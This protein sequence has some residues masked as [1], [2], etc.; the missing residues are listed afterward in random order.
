MLHVMHNGIELVVAISP[1]CVFIVTK[2]QVS[3]AFSSAS[4]SCR[5][6]WPSCLRSH[7]TVDFLELVQEQTQPLPLN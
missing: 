4:R 3:D 7:L 1:A 2:K 6:V 5:A